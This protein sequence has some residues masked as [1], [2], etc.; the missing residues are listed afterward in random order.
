MFV[1]NFFTKAVAETTGCF[2]FFSGSVLGV[3]AHFRASFTNNY[4][5]LEVDEG[6]FSKPYIR[7]KYFPTK[8]GLV[9]LEVEEYNFDLWLSENDKDMAFLRHIAST[10]SRVLN[11]AA[12]QW[13]E[14]IAKMEDPEFGE[15]P[16]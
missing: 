10:C 3:E 4:F 15:I 14:R 1:R 6:L 13:S 16:L 5:C 2:A 12:M 11:K 9:L 8:H 7:V